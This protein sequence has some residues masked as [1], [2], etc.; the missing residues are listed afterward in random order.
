MSHPKEIA[1]ELR[2]ISL[3]FS[4]RGKDENAKF[5]YAAADIVEA[6]F[7]FFGWFNKTYSIVSEH[8]QHP[9]NR[10]GTALNALEDCSISKQD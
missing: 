6:A 10:L 1:S 3:Y 7:D 9:A 4:D 5:M 2:E 8:N